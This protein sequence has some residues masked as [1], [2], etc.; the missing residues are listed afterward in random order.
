MDLEEAKRLYTEASKDIEQGLE[1]LEKELSQLGFGAHDVTKSFLS[2]SNKWEDKKIGK[3]F[4][5]RKVV[6]STTTI[7]IVEE[8]SG[9]KI[10]TELKKVLVTLDAVINATDDLI[11]TKNISIQEKVSSAIVMHFGNLLSQKFLFQLVKSPS[12]ISTPSRK[13]LDIIT[14]GQFR[15]L[16]KIEDV[17]PILYSYLLNISQIPSIEKQTYEK[18]LN[19]SVSEENIIDVSVRCYLWRGRDVDAYLDIASMW[20]GIDTENHERLKKL[21]RSY[22]AIQLLNKDRED[23]DYDIENETKTPLTALSARYGA[24]SQIF[25]EMLGRMHGKLRKDYDSNSLEC[26]VEVVEHLNKLLEKL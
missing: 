3:E 10:P 14:L 23:L 12:Y 15:R 8:F 21:T 20:M 1:S 24:N 25:Q 4:I 19:S 7:P 5:R 26:K 9:K 11:D 17:N 22:R 18:I 16:S 6:R 13:L 2:I